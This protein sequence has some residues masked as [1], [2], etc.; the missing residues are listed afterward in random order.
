MKTILKI[1]ASLILPLFGIEFTVV[2]SNA[3]YGELNA[4]ALI[5]Y[6][7]VTLAAFVYFGITFLFKDESKDV[8]KYPNITGVQGGVK[9]Y[10]S[11]SKPE[12]K[13]PSSKVKKHEQQS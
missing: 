9:P 5:V 3:M 7:Y 6:L 4:S 13:P 1:V 10:A 2:T 12:D 8:V 11:Q